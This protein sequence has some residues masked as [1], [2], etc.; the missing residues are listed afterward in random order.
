MAESETTGATMAPP[1]C[2][3]CGGLVTRRGRRG[4]PAK[5]CSTICKLRRDGQLKAIRHPRPPKRKGRTVHDRTCV[6]CGTTFKHLNPKARCCSG[7]CVLKCAKARQAETRAEQA[8][9]R[10][11]RTCERCGIEF[12][13]R[14]PSGRANRGATVEGRFCSRLCAHDGVEYATPSDARR[15]RKHRRRARERA[16]E[17]ERFSGVEI[18][19]RDG[20]RCGI[21]HRHVDRRLRHPHQMSAS[22][23]HIVPIS[24]GGHH[25]RRN[26]QCAHLKCNV[27]KGTKAAGQLL[28]FG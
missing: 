5:V 19:Q 21:C 3:V 24:E 11:G 13:M 26:V 7:V 20:W 16:G 8:R 25:V 14:R 15:A 10:H 12:V 1:P 22:I 9:R 2:L 17:A 6:A 18:F 23:D 27:A 4:P 28:L